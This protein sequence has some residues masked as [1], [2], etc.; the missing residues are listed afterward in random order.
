MWLLWRLLRYTLEQLP[1][2]TSEAIAGLLGV[3]VSTSEPL[4]ILLGNLV[5]GLL[6]GIT[7]LLL[8]ERRLGQPHDAELARR[9]RL[10]QV[11]LIGLETGVS[12]ALF[13]S[14][15]SEPLLAVAWGVAEGFMYASAARF[16]FGWSYQSEVRTVEALGW[17]WARAGTGAL[18][19][20]I[21]A[22]VAEVIE[23]LLYGY[24]GAERTVVTLLVAG[25]V[26]GGLRGRSAEAKSRPNQGVWLSLRNAFIAALVLAATLA[27]VAWVIRDPVY[28]WQIALLAAVIGASIMGGS[29]VV[30]HFLLRVM[31]HSHQ[32]LPWRYAR[33]LDYASQLVLLR[34]VG[35]GYIFI[36]GLMQSYFANLR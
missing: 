9:Q 27:A 28:A 29:V 12:T 1:A 22:V 34:K 23:S 8:F 36:H 14:F 3:P 11:V 19:G 2:P 13:V 6:V 33:F 31:L 7:L 20:L 25:F 32:Q 16:I 26:L 18:I 5:L 17:S 30:K 35:N 10:G 21:L 15:F 4:T 24:N